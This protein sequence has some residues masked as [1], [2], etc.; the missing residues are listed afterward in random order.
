LLITGERHLRLVLNEHVDHYSQHRPHR[1]LLQ[2]PP[3]GRV[4][5]PA[6]VTG[7]RVLRRNRLGALIHEYAQVA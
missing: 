6:E 3:A 5:P 4:R 1:T 2:N 7:T